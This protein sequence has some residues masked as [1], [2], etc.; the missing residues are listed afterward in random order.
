MRIDQKEKVLARFDHS[1][2]DPIP[3]SADRRVDLNG[4][5]AGFDNVFDF[6]DQEGV[7]MPLG[8]DDDRFT[9]I[10]VRA[11]K[12]K[13]RHAIYHGQDAAS[14]RGQSRD[15]VSGTRCWSQPLELDNRFDVMRGERDPAPAQADDKKQLSHS[16]R[17]FLESRD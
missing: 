6:L 11:P 17:P 14:Q 16:R 13:G 9:A 4:N 5:A 12:T 15:M 7:V 8:G 2:S 3:A 10:L 1:D